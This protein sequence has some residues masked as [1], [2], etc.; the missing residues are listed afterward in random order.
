MARPSL[1]ETRRPELLEAYGRSLLKHGSEGATL[2]RIAEE[3]GVTRGL[4][5]H[6]L[7]N[8]VDVDRALLDHIRER[9]VNG[10]Q[11][12]GA[13]RSPVERLPAIIE[14]MFEGSSDDPTARLVDT[15]LGASADD[16][17]L[18][19]R[20]REMYLELERLLASELAEAYPRSRPAARRR[21]AYG[22]VCLAGMNESL[23]E[24]G[25]P[26]DRAGAARACAEQ[27]VASLG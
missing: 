24:L 12:L 6:Y 11:A 14:G 23:I 1:A 16:P 17:L 25:M 3:A 22:I 4:V 27:L 10:L 8:R 15:L 13:G 19:E 20:L 5:R 7:G 9:Y 2:D 26:A 18:R 21:V